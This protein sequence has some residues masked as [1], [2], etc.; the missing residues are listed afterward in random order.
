MATSIL[1]P[2]ISIPIAE[3]EKVIDSYVPQELFND[4]VASGLQV[5]ASKEGTI[6]LAMEFNRILYRVPIRLQVKKDIGISVAKTNCKLLMQF[7]TIFVIGSDWSI[8]TKTELQQYGWLEKPQLD[9]GILS[10]PI[11]SVLEGVLNSKQQLICDAI[12]AQ[13][14]KL[15]VGNQIRKAIQALPNPFSAPI[16]GPVYWESSPVKTSLHPLEVNDG[17]LHL[18]LGLTSDLSVGIGTAIP[19]STLEV[20]A[21]DFTK[22]KRAPSQLKLKTKTAISTIEK[23]FNKELAGQAYE[24][25]QYTITPS[26]ILISC[27]GQRMTLKSTL[28]GS[29]SGQVTL[30][31]IPFYNQEDKTLYCREVDIELEGTGLKSKSIVMLASK[32][33]KKKVEENLKFPVD[34]I[35]NE[36][37]KQI[38]KYQFEGGVLKAYIVSYKLANLK[39]AI[40]T[41][42]VDVDIESLVT[43][44]RK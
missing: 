22:S 39:M 42:D 30:H 9:L 27:D 20:K 8:R 16:I 34:P 11:A 5:K 25:E 24:V 19:S 28:A 38:N 40:E 21:P 33:I 1:N 3:L 26:N 18:T 6:R 2:L 12:D 37:N 44:E 14:N 36:I 7:K 17:N 32:H 31:G 13:A 35:V 23:I 15:D 29:F 10:V 4:S 41:I 43:I